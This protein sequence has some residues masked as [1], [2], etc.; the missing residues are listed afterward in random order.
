MSPTATIPS[1]ANGNNWQCL[2]GAEKEA[3]TG[4]NYRWPRS[5]SPGEGQV[6]APENEEAF[7]NVRT[8]LA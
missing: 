6:R 3:A 1:R 7:Y 5:P 8:C 4:E 2:R